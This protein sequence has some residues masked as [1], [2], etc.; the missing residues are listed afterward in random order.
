MLIVV[1]APAA[2]DTGTEGAVI[3]KTPEDMVAWLI[4][5]VAEP[6]FDTETV[7]TLLL[8]TTTFPKLRLLLPKEILPGFEGVWS[9]LDAGDVPPPQPTSAPR[10][11]NNATAPSRC[12]TRSSLSST[13][14]DPFNFAFVRM[15][16][17]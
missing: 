3:E 17:P 10:T 8:L 15:E 9:T 12:A 13:D 7:R 2:M 11:A 16:P 6:A 5:N 14:K 1:L 4:V